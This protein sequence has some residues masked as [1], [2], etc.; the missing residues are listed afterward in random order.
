MNLYYTVT[1]FITIISMLIIQICLKNSNT[2][3][4][5]TKK[6]FGLFFNIVAIAAFCEWFAIFTE[7]WK[8][9]RL[10]HIVIKTVELSLAP[11]LAVIFSWSLTRKYDIKAIAILVIHAIM[12]ALSGWLGFIFYVDN[13]NVYH[14][15]P[16]YV[17]YI[18]IYLLSFIYCIS[19]IS[20]NIK[21]YQYNGA[22]FFSSL[23][24]FLLVGVFGQLILNFKICYLVIG[25]ISIMTYVFTLEMIQQTDE[26]TGLLNR[27]GYENYIR[28]L[29]EKSVIIFFDVNKFKDIND[30]Y[31]H[32]FGD[33]VLKELGI[34]LKETYL[35]SG[36]CFRYGGDEFCVILNRNLDSV[37][38]L[39]RNFCLAV[40]N[41][42]ETITNLP[43][44]SLGYAYFDPS[45]Q[46]IN[47][48]IK[49]AD[50]MMYNCKK[51]K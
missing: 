34:I 36:K 27:R 40:D 3:N 23:M 8:N 33:I 26:L 10:L 17:I 19:I 21:K 42:R 22:I 24:I 6:L 25:I 7:Q 43:N 46:N 2:L 12:E 47:D 5:K 1:T 39:N 44:V 4:L 50:D 32:H 16:A 15:G 30:I 11:C 14:H 9:L 38:V 41:K 37:E 18:I 35:N 28:N 20:K 48:A 29:N 51:N 49:Q 13:N 45:N 31:G